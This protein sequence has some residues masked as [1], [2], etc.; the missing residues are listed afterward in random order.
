MLERP[1]GQHREQVY[2]SRLGGGEKEVLMWRKE[3]GLCQNLWILGP[4]SSATDVTLASSVLFLALIPY[5]QTRS[6]D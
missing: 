2:E 6:G 3:R 4:G 1:A 5:L